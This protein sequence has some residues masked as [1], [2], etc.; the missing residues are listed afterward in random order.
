M[1]GR[2]PIRGVH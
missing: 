2:V 1:L